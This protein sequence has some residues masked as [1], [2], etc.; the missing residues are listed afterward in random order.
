ARQCTTPG[1]QIPARPVSHLAPPPGSPSSMIPLQSSSL[2]LQTSTVEP[3]ATH[4]SFPALQRITPAPQVPSQGSPPPGSPSS[5]SPLQSSSSPLQT[6]AVEIGEM[7]E[8]V[9]ARQW[10]VPLAQAPGIPVSQ[11][12]PPPGSPSSTCASASSSLPLQVSTGVVIEGSPTP[13]SP[14]A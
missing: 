7:Q 11:E 5:T 8:S 13:Q 9:P 2:P 4:D 14:T 3:S 1:P 6:S 10:S 12:A